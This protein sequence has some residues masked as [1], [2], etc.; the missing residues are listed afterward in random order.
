[1]AIAEDNPDGTFWALT[2]FKAI[3][4]LIFSVPHQPN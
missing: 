3:P 1:V 2:F 4:F